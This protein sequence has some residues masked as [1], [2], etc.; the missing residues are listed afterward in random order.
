MK[1]SF[2]AG[3]DTPDLVL[4]AGTH[5]VRERTV[6][7]AGGVVLT[8]RLSV[9]S[10]KDQV[11][12]YPNVHG[13][14]VTTAGSTGQ[15]DGKEYLYDPYGQPIHPN[16]L[17]IGTDAAKDA[18]PD[19]AAGLYDNG[20]L[21]QHQRGYEHSGKLALVQMGARVYAPFLGRFLSVD[22]VEGGSSN[23]YDYV[24]A[25]RSATS[26]WTGSCRVPGPAAS[27]A[28][29]SWTRPR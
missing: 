19:T 6:P 18:V 2:T 12:G 14:V 17:A 16:T 24:S 10:P 20:W 23:D 21:G 8:V 5:Q 27:S 7:L 9:T 13:D 15:P 11:W 25:D 22:P 3:G 28:A 4:E 1:Y 29:R 26:T